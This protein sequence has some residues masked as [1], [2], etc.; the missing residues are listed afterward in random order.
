M[1]G[2]IKAL[3]EWRCYLEGGLPLVV[4]TDHSANTFFP[5]QTV[6][7]GRQARWADFLSRFTIE[8][9]HTP[10]STNPADGLSRLHGGLILAGSTS[11]LYDMDP[12]LVSDFSEAYQWDEN[13][14]NDAWTK[15]HNL[16]HTSISGTEFW[17]TLDYKLVVPDTCVQ[18]VLTA[19]HCNAFAGH[20]GESGTLDLVARHFWWPTLR[21]DV[22]TFVTGCDHCQKAKALTSN[23]AGL[24]QPLKIPDERF[25]TWSLDFVTALPRTKAGNDAVLVFVDK[26]TKMVHIAACKKKCSTEQ[27]AALLTD[28]IIKLHGVPKVLVSDRDTRFTSKYWQA[29]CKA[30]NIKTSM[31]TA[32]HPQSDGQT[33]RANR[34]IEEVLRASLVADMTGWET[35]LPYVEFSI[36]NCVQAS[37]KFSPFFLA[38]GLH[39]RVPVTPSD[40]WS[41]CP[42]P[43]LSSSFDKIADAVAQAKLNMQA[44]QERQSHYANKDRKY[45]TFESGQMALLSSKNIIITGKNK[46]KL[47]PKFLGPFLITE[48]VGK[49][50]ARLELPT[51]WGLHDV[52]HVSPPTIQ[53]HSTS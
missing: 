44:A 35:L 42:L 19:H 36:N 8:W 33:E 52:F 37:T 38:Y 24:L 45:H 13:F 17:E 9:K 15:K 6:I 39:P 51:D 27:T 3:K 46:R 23:P 4:L 18:R 47:F 26:F 31:S 41:S 53:G 20:R 30:R 14:L 50:A 49:N 1:L 25:H 16:V 11:L 34:V 28:T 29:F 48:M 12:N 32:Y 5:R 43:T 21:R 10:G 7:S 22:H 2:V 40:D